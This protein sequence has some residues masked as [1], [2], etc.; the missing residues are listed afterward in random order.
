MTNV[1]IVTGGSRGIGAATAKLVASHGHAVCVNYVNDEKAAERVVSDIAAAGGKALAVKADTANEAE[2]VAMFETV[3]KELGPVTGLVNNAGINGGRKRVE[4]LSPDDVDQAWTL[5]RE[6]VEGVRPQLPPGAGAPDVERRYPVAL[7]GVEPHV[8][9][10]LA[11]PRRRRAEG[12]LV[13]RVRG[14]VAHGG[15][16]CVPDGGGP[17][18]HRGCDARR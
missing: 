16:R 12:H 13:H 8:H 10:L 1:T 5:I 9:V 6:Q 17:R 18:G 3:D 14:D 7:V 2:V 15:R 11:V 4:D